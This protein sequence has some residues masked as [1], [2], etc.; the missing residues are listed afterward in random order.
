MQAEGPQCCHWVSWV[1]LSLR[2]HEAAVSMAWLSNTKVAS[3][4]AFL[5]VK[6]LVLNSKLF[7]I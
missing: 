6:M 7:L 1:E 5:E 2:V 3:R 4:F